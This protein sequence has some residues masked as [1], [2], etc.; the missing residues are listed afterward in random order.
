MKTIDFDAYDDFDVKDGGRR[1]RRPK[2][3]HKPKRNKWQVPGSLYEPDARGRNE[4]L[5]AP[6]VNASSEE[7]AW[8]AENLS[9]FYY[10]KLITDVAR[11][12]KGGKEANVY[13]C[14]GHPD[15]GRDLIA[16]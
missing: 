4:S 14:P 6:S 16:A 1:P 8:I 9:Q 2:P 10:G 3:Y 5:F 11:R 12:V 7:L 15:S 13:C